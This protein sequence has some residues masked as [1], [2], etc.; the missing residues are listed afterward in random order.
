MLKQNIK[1]FTMLMQL[2]I[3]KEID[4]LAENGEKRLLKAA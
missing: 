3:N 4:D 2:A 1:V